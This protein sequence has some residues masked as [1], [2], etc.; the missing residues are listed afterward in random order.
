MNSK[1]HLPADLSGLPDPLRKMVEHLNA[2]VAADRHVVSTLFSNEVAAPIDE[3]LV[4]KLDPFFVLMQ[5]PDEAQPHL[6]P[7]GVVNGLVHAMG[8]EQYS[9]YREVDEV[10]DVIDFFG[11]IER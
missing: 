1:R 5:E 9:I 8:Y 7:L 2:A 3:S 10:T 6:G 4:S 11:V